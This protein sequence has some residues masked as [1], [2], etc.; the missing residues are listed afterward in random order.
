M[1]G[2]EVALTQI[3]LPTEE[4]IR[5]LPDLDAMGINSGQLFPDMTGLTEQVMMRLAYS[6]L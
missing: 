2:D 3:I 5:A 1:E 6:E 4:A